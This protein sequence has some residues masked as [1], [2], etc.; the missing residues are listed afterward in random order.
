MVKRDGKITGVLMITLLS[1]CTAL[2]ESR[3]TPRYLVGGATS[4][5]VAEVLPLIRRSH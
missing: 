5:M 4:S 2:Q 1:S 3:D